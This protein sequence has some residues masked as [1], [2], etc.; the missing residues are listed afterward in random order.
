MSEHRQ[1]QP[2]DYHRCLDTVFSSPSAC[3][4]LLL[5]LAQTT[6]A[7][8]RA[9]WA[10]WR[11]QDSPP[12]GPKVKTQ[13][14]PEV[15]LMMAEATLAGERAAEERLWRELYDLMGI[16]P[17]QESNAELVFWIRTRIERLEKRVGELEQPAADGGSRG[18]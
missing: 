12:Y 10:P 4:E 6:D 5:R 1:L 2:P 16:P 11:D 14:R 8:L 18:A 17:M 9:R 3:R 15:Q 13:V 7:D